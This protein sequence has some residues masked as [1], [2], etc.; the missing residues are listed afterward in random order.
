M[1]NDGG[2]AFPQICENCGC[3]SDDH[4][5]ISRKCKNGRT[6]EKLIPYEKYYEIKNSMLAEDSEFEARGEK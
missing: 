2:A 3:I 6:Y 4:T 1:T 5:W